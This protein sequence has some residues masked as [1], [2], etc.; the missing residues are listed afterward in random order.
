MEKLVSDTVVTITRAWDTCYQPT[1]WEI[2]RLVARLRTATTQAVPSED[3]FFVACVRAAVEPWPGRDVTTEEVRTV[4]ESLHRAHGVT[5]PSGTLVA[6][7]LK[8]RMRELFG[9]PR[10]NKTKRNGKSYRGYRR[11]RLRTH[12]A[13]SPGGQDTVDQGGHIT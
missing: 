11:M 2:R 6:R 4:I 1:P 7:W 9:V 3:D 10:T 13:I 8:R 12:P 5:M